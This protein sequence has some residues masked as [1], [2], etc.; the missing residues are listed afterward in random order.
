MIAAVTL[1]LLFVLSGQDLRLHF[2]SAIDQTD[3][4]YRL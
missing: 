2:R 1:P 4:P 3:Q